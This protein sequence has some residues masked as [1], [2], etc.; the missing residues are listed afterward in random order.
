VAK[1]LNCLEAVKRSN[2]LEAVKRSN[3]LEAVKRSNR[4]EVAERSNSRCAMSPPGPALEDLRED[5][6]MRWRY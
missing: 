1:R 2:C 6:G 5:L 4:L 3:C